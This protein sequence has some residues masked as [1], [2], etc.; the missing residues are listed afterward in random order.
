M[1]QQYAKRVSVTDLCMEST[2]CRTE[3]VVADDDED[4]DDGDNI[5]IIKTMTM[6]A[7]TLKGAITYFFNLLTVSNTYPPEAG[8][9]L[10][11][12]QVQHIGRFSRAT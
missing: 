4:D 7:L 2:C 11:A 10:C 3:I 6:I 12:N 9:Q 8:A 5:M 1:S